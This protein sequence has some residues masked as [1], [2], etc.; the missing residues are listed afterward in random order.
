MDY[1]KKRKM[2]YVAKGMNYKMPNMTDCEYSSYRG[3]EWLYFMW[4]G[5]RV[6]FYACRSY[7]AFTH[8]EITEEWKYKPIGR[9]FIKGDS[10]REV[11]ENGLS[12]IV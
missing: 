12:K 6:E 11:I 8:Y 9:R 7:I 3:S 10:M 5:L 1:L 4:N 2:Y